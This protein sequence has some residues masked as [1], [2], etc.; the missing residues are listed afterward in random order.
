VRL[1]PHAATD[2]YIRRQNRLGRPAML[3]FHPWELDTEQPRVQVGALPGFQ[4]YVNLS[5]T[6]GKLDR[7]LAAHP[8]GAVK[9]ILAS[10]AM[11]AM[12]EREP[13]ALHSLAPQ[14]MAA[15]SHAVLAGPHNGPHTG[16][17]ART[18]VPVLG[19]RTGMLAT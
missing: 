12:L 4:H 6:E 11:G 8:F 15:P 10:S 17:A 19:P 2:G 13:V 7:L 18:A 14:P 9:E 16:Y 1:Y 5:G 3:Y